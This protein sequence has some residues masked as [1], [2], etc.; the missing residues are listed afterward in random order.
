MFTYQVRPRVLK[1]AVDQPL[2]FPSNGTVRMHL[3]PDQPFGLE[4]GGGRTAV[5]NV[6]ASVFFNANT[7]AHYVQSRQPLEPLD[8]TIQEP[9]RTIQLKGNVFIV[10]QRFE[11]NRELTETIESLYLGIPMLLAVDLA[12]PP[13]VTMIDG[14]IAGVNFRWELAD[15]RAR[16]EITTQERQEQA[17]VDSWNRLGVL[18]AS[19]R[20]RLQAALH[21]FHVA[22]RLSRRAEVA[23]EFLPEVLLNLAKVLEVLFPPGGDG[24]TRDS[25]RRGLHRL[26]FSND[27]I[28][29][30]YLPAMALRNEIDVGHV[31]LSLFTKEQ[32]AVIHGYVERTEPAFRLL[33]RRIFESIAAATFDVPEYIPT[34]ASGE[35]V[36]LI[37]RLR[38]HINAP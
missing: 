33:F 26:G 30:D 1:L 13:V 4:A 12:D 8:V 29:A 34:A 16:F 38:E 23:G 17:V 25:A 11:S 35:A 31:D 36:R 9:S 37:D 2:P 24:H 18:A 10:S 19:N 27:T 14:E 20:R 6:A 22:L 15:W 5:R 3:A 28:E 7:G 21:Y 32:L